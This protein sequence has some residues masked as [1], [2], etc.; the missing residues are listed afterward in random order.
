MRTCRSISFRSSNWPATCCPMPR[1]SN[2]LRTG[3]HRNTMLNEEGGIDPL[4]YR[5]YAMV[6]RVATTG[7]VW[8]G[9]T[10]GCAQCHTHKYDPLSHRTTS[11]YGAPEQHRGARFPDSHAE[12]LD[13]QRRPTKQIAGWKSTRTTFPRGRRG[14][15]RGRSQRDVP[16]ICKP[17]LKSGSNRRDRNPPIGRRFDPRKWRP[18]CHGWRSWRTDPFSPPATSPSVTYFH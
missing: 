13:A 18:I 6:D 4:E 15:G 9:L 10:T 14:R 17:N 5:F 3:F 1:A 7:T 2:A 16:S 11:I 12:I 8:M